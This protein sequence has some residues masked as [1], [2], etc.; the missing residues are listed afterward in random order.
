MLVE[1][2]TVLMVHMDDVLF[3]GTRKFFGGTVSSK[4]GVDSISFLKR[5]FVKVDHGLALVPG[6]NIDKLVRNFEGHFGP[7]R[8]QQVACDGS[9]Q[10]PD[11]SAGLVSHDAYA[12]RSAVGGLLYLA[13]DRSDLLFPVKELPAKTAQPTVTLWQRLK[14]FMG[15][16][17][18]TASYA[19]VLQ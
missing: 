1:I 12:Y 5:K 11:V 7:V 13:R 10:L 6:T 4:D 17:K 18:G 9:I 3:T 8:I 16:V 15:Y 2:E 14:K 19:V